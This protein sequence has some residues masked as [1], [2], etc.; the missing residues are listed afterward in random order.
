MV[1]FGIQLLLTFLSGPVLGAA[2]AL[3]STN[4]SE[5]RL[6]LCDEVAQTITDTNVVLATSFILAATIR[7]AQTPTLSEIDLINQ[8]TTL[9]SIVVTGS[10][11]AS[12]TFGRTPTRKKWFYAVC[13]MTGIPE[14]VVNHTLPHLE[15]MGAVARAARSSCNLQPELK[16]W[17]A[18][19]PF[20]WLFLPTGILGLACLGCKYAPRTTAMFTSN[21][22]RNQRVLRAIR[23]A[24]SHPRIIRGLISFVGLCW[25]VVGFGEWAWIQHRRWQMQ[26]LLHERNQ[27]GVWGFGQVMALLVWVF[28]AEQIVSQVQGK[29]DFCA[30]LCSWLMHA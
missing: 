27:N 30:M 9:Q 22:P 21:K 10:L 13:F 3:I 12:L 1:S 18:M 11:L 17:N 7:L 6:H 28:L 2:I 25:S 26:S 19:P 24:Q 15:I 4:F 5:D 20:N 29:S 14:A 16:T 23:A 8:S